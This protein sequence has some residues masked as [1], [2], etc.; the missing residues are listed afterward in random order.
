[1]VEDGCGKKKD[2]KDNED[3][4]EDNKGLEHYI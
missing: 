2:D 3:G 1:M 4:G